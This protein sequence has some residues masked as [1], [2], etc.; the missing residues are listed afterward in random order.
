MVS[1]SRES[2]AVMTEARGAK[3]FLHLLSETQKKESRDKNWKL[4]HNKFQDR[5]NFQD[6]LQE[7]IQAR[8]SGAHLQSGNADLD[9]AADHAADSRMAFAATPSRS[10]KQ[11]FQDVREGFNL[12]SGNADLDDAVHQ[13]D[14]RMASAAASAA[15]HAAASAADH[16]AI[17]AADPTLDLAKK[18]NEVYTF[19]EWRIK[20][21]LAPFLLWVKEKLWVL[22]RGWMKTTGGRQRR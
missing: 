11:T 19:V 12:Q 14:S 7:A 15:D 16:A 1:R 8:R 18:M 17:S 6:L 9:E 2:F 4:R 3:L 22:S 5:L 10:P 21:V 13:L 20:V